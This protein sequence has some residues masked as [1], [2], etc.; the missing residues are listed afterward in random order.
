MKQDEINDFKEQFDKHID[1]LITMN[2]Q[3]DCLP[4][5]NK[6]C[7]KES[8]ID[9]EK[10]ERILRRVLKQGYQYNGPDESYYMCEKW[11][12]KQFTKKKNK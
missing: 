1:N 3:M 6:V 10:V 8:D 2:N 12:D 11:L 5:D 9:E 7:N 4:K